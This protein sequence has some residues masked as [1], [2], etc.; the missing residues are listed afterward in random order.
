MTLKSITVSNFK[1]FN[2]PATVVFD[3]HMTVIVGRNNAGKSTLLQTLRFRMGSA[4]HRSR[5]TL[6]KR[7]DLR[8]VESRCTGEVFLPGGAVDDILRNYDGQFCIL[9]PNESVLPASSEEMAEAGRQALRDFQTYGARVPIAAGHQAS[10]LVDGMYMGRYFPVDLGGHGMWLTF[11]GAANGEYPTSFGAFQAP[12][13]ATPGDLAGVLTQA[14][15]DSTYVFRAERMNVGTCSFGR[16]THLAPDASNLPEVLNALQGNRAR[17]TKYIAHVRRVLPQIANLSVRPHPDSDMQLEVL[18]WSGDPE[19]DRDDLA[20]PLEQSGTGVSQVLAMLYVITT[21]DTRRVIAIDEPNSF[22]HP[23]AVRALL[24]VFRE[25]PQHQFILA[26]HSP[27]VIAAANPGKLYLLENED[28]E[29]RVTLIDHAKSHEQRRTLDAVGADLGDVLGPEKILWVEGKTEER[30][31]PLIA[32]ALTPID[33]GKIAILG[34]VAT[35]DFEGKR[36]K[37]RIHLSSSV[38]ARLS[39]GV[40]LVPPAVGFVFDREMLTADDIDRLKSNAGSPIH[41]LPRRLYENYLLNPDAIAAVL[42]NTATGKQAPFD[43]AQIKAWIEANRTRF[44][45]KRDAWQGTVDGAKLLKAL[46]AELTETREVY[47][48]V[49]HGPELTAWLLSRSPDDLRE[50]G[51]LLEEACAP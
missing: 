26:T 29:T 11:P 30:C 34:V 41:F 32:R 9:M 33:L 12:L 31:F 1:C 48:K 7:G 37:R 24:E 4:P 36:D 14:H 49:A 13:G 46:F 21:S 40:G 2:E 3:D 5:V 8:S 19:S 23:G 17:F 47:D 20:I 28:N 43:G 50:V 15:V 35:G 10:P 6:P 51:Q 38:Y 45:A 16:R 44:G 27:A 25:H 39:E 42:N 22:L 18:I